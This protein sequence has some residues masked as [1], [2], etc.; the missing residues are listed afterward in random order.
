M[1]IAS[2]LKGFE[3]EKRRRDLVGVEIDLGIGK[4][5]HELLHAL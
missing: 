3:G 2:W 4:S 1:T 5:A